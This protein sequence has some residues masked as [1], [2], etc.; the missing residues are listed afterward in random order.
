MTTCSE[1]VEQIFDKCCRSHRLDPNAEQ[2]VLHYISRP[3]AL[4]GGKLKS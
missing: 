3:A 2:K 1:L 4:D